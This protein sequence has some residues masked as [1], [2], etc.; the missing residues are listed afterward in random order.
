[1]LQLQDLHNIA[2][3]MKEIRETYIALLNE[4]VLNLSYWCITICYN[5]LKGE[6]EVTYYPLFLALLLFD[7]LNGQSFKNIVR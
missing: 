5:C 1:M 2:K 7:F 3:W 6:G 4:V